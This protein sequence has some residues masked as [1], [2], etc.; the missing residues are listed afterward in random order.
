MHLDL[1]WTL[2]EAHDNERALAEVN[3]A[4]ELDSTLPETWSALCVLQTQAGHFDS[5][6]AALDR[7][8]ELGGSEYDGQRGYIFALA[9]R[10]E[11][12]L[13]E[14]E[15]WANRE[16]QPNI[17]AAL[18]RVGLGE[19]ESALTSLEQL[20]AERYHWRWFDPSWD[21]IR[22][23]PRFQAMLRSNGVVQQ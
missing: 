9:G 15:R 23:D 2:Q 18:I 1:A 12:A 10:R 21:P 17:G 6:L 20:N 3:I 5:A 16:P 8:L 22:H 14:F 7:Y 11:D 19:W 13:A 4:M